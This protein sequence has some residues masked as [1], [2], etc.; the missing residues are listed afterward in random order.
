MLRSCLSKRA[1]DYPM[2]E[3]WAKVA[4]PFL[5]SLGTRHNGQPLTIPGM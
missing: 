5:T 3:E 1:D 4:V 2:P